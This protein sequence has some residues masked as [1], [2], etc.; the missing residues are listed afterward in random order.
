MKCISSDVCVCPFLPLRKKRNIPPSYTVWVCGGYPY[1]VSYTHAHA[2]ACDLVYMMAFTFSVCTII[3]KCM[4]GPDQPY[5]C[6]LISLLLGYI[7]HRMYQN[8]PDPTT[9]TTT[10]TSVLFHFIIDD[11]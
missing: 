11:G 7:R 2:T 9:I 6:T 4:Y 5:F 3:V 1:T 10:H 8:S